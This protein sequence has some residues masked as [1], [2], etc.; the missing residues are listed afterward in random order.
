MK[1]SAPRTSRLIG[2]MILTIRGQK[3]ILD[4]DLAALYGVP[5]FRF[6]EAVKRNRKRFPDDFMFQLTT[7]ELAALTSQ[8]AMSKTGGG[9]FPRRCRGN[10]NL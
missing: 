2:N 4:H 10:P 9:R 5:T 8:I 7:E 3:V 1:K 6:N